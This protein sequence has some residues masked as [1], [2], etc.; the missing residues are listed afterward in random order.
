MP[1]ISQ[2]RADLIKWM[3]I[4]GVGEVGVILGILFA[5]FK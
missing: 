2:T 1:Q 4:L 3:S 5:F